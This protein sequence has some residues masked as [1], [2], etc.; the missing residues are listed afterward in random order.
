MGYTLRNVFF[1][2]AFGLLAAKGLGYL[3]DITPNDP[4]ARA[5]RVTQQQ[6][7]RAAA[8]A[9][10]GAEDEMVL[11]AAANGHFTVAASVD[12]APVKFLI[13]TGASTVILS[14]ADAE[15]LGLHPSRLDYNAVFET[16]NG[17][18]RAALVT[19]GELRIGS[20]ELDDVDAAVI[21]APMAISLLGMS[22]LDRL[23]S[24]EVEGDRMIL[25]W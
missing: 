18:T 14:P 6:P 2:L 8:K 9:H 19:L 23:D 12:G 7:G 1:L 22:A 24:Y 5:P 21:Q 16:A 11:Q 13:D 25:R 10:A 3:A 17:K 20:L 4:D 15:R